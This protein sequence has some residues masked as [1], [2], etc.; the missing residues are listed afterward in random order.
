[1]V[2]LCKPSDFYPADKCFASHNVP[3]ILDEETLHDLKNME[4]MYVKILTAMCS[5]GARLPPETQR[6]MP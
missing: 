3:N 2:L 4:T 6:K 1:M 5:L